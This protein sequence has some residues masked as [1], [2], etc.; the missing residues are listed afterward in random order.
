MN[1][2]QYPPPVLPTIN[3]DVLLPDIIDFNITNNP[4]QPFYIFVDSS[5]GFHVITQ[6]EFG[7]AAHRVAY[8]LRPQCAGRN[9]EVVAILA[10]TDTIMYSTIISGAIV[11][12]LV[13]FPISDRN[14]PVAVAELL[15][16]TSSHRLLV[17][18]AAL[19]SLIDETKARLSAS[20]YEVQIEEIPS[21]VVA[22]P[23]LA[24]ETVGYPFEPYPT[25]SHR[26]TAMDTCMIIHSSGSTGIP[27]P[28]PQTHLYWIQIAAIPELREHI[29]RLVLGSMALPPFHAFGVG[30]QIIHPAYNV[31]ACAVFPPTSAV[32]GGSP[33]VPS[34][35]IVLEHAKATGTNAIFTIPAFIQAWSNSSDAIDY[36]KTLE[37]VSYAGGP[38][39][40]K[41]GNNL[42]ASGVQLYPFYGGTE[43]GGPT[44]ILRDKA[45]VMEWEYMRF[46]PHT[47]VRWVPQG[48]DTFECQLLACEMSRPAVNNLPDVE[49][50]ATA[51]IFKSHPTKE[52]LWKI[53]GRLDDVIIHSSGE[54]TVPGPMEVI[55][56]SNPCV[57]GAVVFGRE[58]TQTGV[59]IELASGAE[60]NVGNEAQL[61][62]AR[63]E[64]WPTIEEANN[65][66]PAFSKIFKEM[67][68][69]AFKEK[70][71]PRAGKGT[72]MRIAAL[73]L[74]ASEIS[75][76][77]DNIENNV[78]YNSRPRSWDIIDVEN[79]ILGQA[80]E[81][82]SRE[83][84]FL[85]VDLFD[86]GLDSL[87]ATILRLRITH[88]MR[89]SGNLFAKVS[90]NLDQNLIYNMPT[91][92]RLAAYLTSPP[93]LER[94]PQLLTETELIEELI[95]KYSINLGL[96]PLESAAPSAQ[97]LDLVVLLT[98]STGHLGSHILANLLKE[99]RITRI[100]AFNRDNQK[101]KS[102][103]DRHGERFVDI[104]I[105]PRILKNEK[106]ILITG[107]ARRFDLGIEAE[108]YREISL[109][110]NVV[111]HNAWQIDFNLPLL[112]YEPNIQSSRYFVD[113]VRGGPN[114]SCTR[115]LFISSVASA[116]SWD[117]TRGPVI[118]DLVAV[119]SALGGGYGEAKY[120]V[121]RMLVN[122]GL[123]ATS[124]RLGQICG[125]SPK[126]SWPTSEWF[127]LLVKSSVALGELPILGG[128]APWLPA[129]S[130]AQAIIDIV[131]Y[132][133]SN[134]L[135][136][137]LNIVHPRPVEQRVII[138][139]VISAVKNVLDLQLRTVSLDQWLSSI[140]AYADKATSD[141]LKTVPAIK[142]ISFF[143][144][145]AAMSKA[146]STNLTQSITTVLHPNRLKQIGDDDIKTWVEYW[147]GVGYFRE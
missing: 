1:L 80:I 123:Q 90:Q 126:G 42:A 91:I 77:Y 97:N 145:S 92:K 27:K 25:L 115:F 142:L 62:L 69:F 114:A 106:L 75:A 121:E 72:V 100:Y 108:L 127:P 49:G 98:G 120:I 78:A 128:I 50:Y 17:T 81:L 99:D 134:S 76:L 59:L 67:I 43:F 139:G 53:V 54:K 102:L 51:D 140:E 136:Q 110:V 117:D 125:G 96:L 14:T 3:Q 109:S 74:Y 45:E 22:Y 19:K 124:L 64:L 116:Q 111:I 2:N 39:P 10:H 33:V 112:S 30:Y 130:M 138:N 89:S 66:A 5:K 35:N 113:L 20:S 38:L 93:G 4:T 18:Y 101:S 65:V 107:D 147:N 61:A 73:N 31:L 131:L 29:P 32:S 85:D 132:P 34:P 94:A 36:L 79:W 118:E 48:D 11:A 86:Q 12:G 44:C 28:I 21:L 57:Q 63:N 104:G 68:L 71:L 52:G 95:A 144:R 26:P 105:D 83:N 24:H 119:S 9:G 55:I 87:S 37:F 16:K 146:F 137:V 143:R 41:L 46:Y 70:P 141:D 60:V 13:P 129:D 40:P 103:L 135:P 6:L 84:I 133:L 8:A 88:A 56:M 15:M 47:K 7:R 23:Q 82:T 58:R 122:S